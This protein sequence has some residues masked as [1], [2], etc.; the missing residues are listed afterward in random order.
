MELGVWGGAG[1]GLECGWMCRMG[2]RVGWVGAG[3]E[4]GVEQEGTRWD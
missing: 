1:V 4:L 2:L 3:E